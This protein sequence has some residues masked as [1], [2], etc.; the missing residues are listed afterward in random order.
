MAAKNRG[1]KRFHGCSAPGSRLLGV[2]SLDAAAGNK[3]REANL[4]GITRKAL[5]VRLK[6]MEKL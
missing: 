6:Q 3:S 4:L 2:K 1:N 5:Y